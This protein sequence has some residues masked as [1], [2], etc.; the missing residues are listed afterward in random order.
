VTDHR[1]VA[2]FAVRGW[3]IIKYIEFE[4][5]HGPCLLTKRDA[6]PLDARP[7]PLGVPR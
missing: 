5:D 6:T 3:Q 4:I 2:E 1:T 7:E